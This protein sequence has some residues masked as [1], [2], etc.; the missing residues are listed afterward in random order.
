MKLFE[1]DDEEKEPTMLVTPRENRLV[2]FRGDT[3]HAVEGYKSETNQRRISL[4]LEQYYLPPVAYNQSIDWECEH[5]EN[6]RKKMAANGDLS[7]K[8]PPYSE[9]V[10]L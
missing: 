9:A 5:C 1:N 6:M 2:R 7:T 8:I 3:Y 4:V 10:E